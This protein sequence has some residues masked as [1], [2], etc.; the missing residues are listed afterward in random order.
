MKLTST[1]H[2]PGFRYKKL[3]TRKIE[4]SNGVYLFLDVLARKVIHQKL[5]QSGLSIGIECSFAMKLL[6]DEWKFPTNRYH[7]WEKRIPSIDAPHNE[8]TS[9]LVTN[10]ILAFRKL[11][12]YTPMIF[13]WSTWVVLANDAKACGYHLPLQGGH[14]GKGT[15]VLQ[16]HPESFAHRYQFS[17]KTP[18]SRA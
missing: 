10:L 15:V 18:P 11:S 3:R 12:L 14:S 6:W 13:R 4:K 5:L 1:R 2:F 9:T 17:S 7:P 16:V 8:A